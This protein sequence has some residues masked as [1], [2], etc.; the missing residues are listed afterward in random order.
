ME[1]ENVVR[2]ISKKLRFR[3][4]IHKQHGKLVQTLFKSTP[5]HLYH[6]YWLL[7]RKLSCK[8]STLL[9]CQILGLLVN[10]LAADGKY[11]ALNRENLTVPIEMQW[12]Q[13][14]KTFSEFFSAFSKLLSQ[15]LACRKDRLFTIQ[16]PWQWSINMMKV[17]W[18]IFQQC[19]SPFTMLLVEGASETGHFRHLFNHIFGVHNFTYAKATSVIFFFKMFKI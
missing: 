19:F 16:L 13:K 7:P 15:D 18:C 1:S 8:K 6:F 9:A 4:P 12:S 17:L 2:Q 5:H 11:S 10:T 3:E 14:E